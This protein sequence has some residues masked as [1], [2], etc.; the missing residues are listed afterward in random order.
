[1]KVVTRFQ[2]RSIVPVVSRMES[3]TRNMTSLSSIL[4]TSLSLS[5]TAEPTTLFHF[6]TSLLS[7]YISHSIH[8]A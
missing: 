6:P 8:G 3:P 5:F 1:M 4:E 2:E 7:R